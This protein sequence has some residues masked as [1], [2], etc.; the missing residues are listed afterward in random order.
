MGNV[1]WFTF[2]L[3][4]VLALSSCTNAIPKLVSFQPESSL[5]MAATIS[6]LEAEQTASESDVTNKSI[7]VISSIAKPYP[8]RVFYSLTG[9]AIYTVNHNLPASGFITIPA[10]GI[11]GQIIFNTLNYPLG[12]KNTFF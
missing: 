7:T 5:A 2:A 8:I 4:M 9:D 6:V 11:S 1:G 10:N 12:T 3:L